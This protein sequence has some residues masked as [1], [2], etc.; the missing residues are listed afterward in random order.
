MH[1]RI[2][3]L[4][5]EAESDLW[6]PA[7][8]EPI[9]QV[10]LAHTNLVFSVSHLEHLRQLGFEFSR[11]EAAAVV[12]L[13]RYAGYLLGIAP[14]L[15]CASEAEGHRLMKMIESAHVVPD[16]D[17]LKLTRA[18]MTVAL[19][20]LILAL[21]GAGGTPRTLAGPVLLRRFP[22]SPGTPPGARA[23]L[24]IPVV[25]PLRPPRGAGHRG[26]GRVPA[27]ARARPA[28]V[29]RGPRHVVDRSMPVGQ[30]GRGCPGVPDAGEAGSGARTPEG[31][32]GT[33]GPPRGSPRPR[34]RPAPHPVGAS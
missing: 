21:S 11:A 7:W 29:D 16:A 32:P 1:A 24:S 5:K 4:L 20:Q 31:R 25:Q 30:P 19:P 34:P 2:R 9:N 26:A 28:A 27:P 10:F 23:G 13:W 18:L 15:L 3:R 6:N 12:Q 33:A 8:G 22:Q 17:S 14:D